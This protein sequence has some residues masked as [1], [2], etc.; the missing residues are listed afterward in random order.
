MKKQKSLTNSEIAAFCRQTAL[1][2]QAGITPAEGMDILIHDTIHESGKALLQEISDACNQGSNF[3]QALEETGVFPPYVV[4]LVALGEESEIWIP[5]FPPW[6]TI[7]NGRNPYP[8]T[9]ALL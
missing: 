3:Y 9:F 1:I 6:P 2:I 5:C 7:M 4:K 8:I